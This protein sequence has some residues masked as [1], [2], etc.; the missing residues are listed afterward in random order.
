MTIK[1]D[2]GAAREKC[3][4]AHYCRVCGRAPVEAA[5]I[6]P[7]SRISAGL[8][9]EDPKNICPLCRLC[10]VAYDQGKLDLLPHL[11][12]SE[13]G[14]AAELVGIAEAYQRTTNQRLEA[15]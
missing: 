11:Y 3:N 1:R 9:G 2:W 15:A 10:H 7:R 6:I 5:H 4:A 12:P 14:Y 13:Q 8:G